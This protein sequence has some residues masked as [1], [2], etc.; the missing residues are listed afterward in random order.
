MHT[1]DDKKRIVNIALKLLAGKIE[2][3]ELDPDDDSAVQ[4]ELRKCVHEATVVYN[5]ALEY[6]SG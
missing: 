1:A 6:V 5:A 3:K 2:K 4:R